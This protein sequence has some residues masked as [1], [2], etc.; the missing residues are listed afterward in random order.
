MNHPQDN[1][2]LKVYYNANYVTYRGKG[3]KEKTEVFEARKYW[4]LLAWN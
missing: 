4:L 3:R 1:P 2:Y